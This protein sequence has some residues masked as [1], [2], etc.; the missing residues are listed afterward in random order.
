MLE[1]MSTTASLLG[2]GA[3]EWEALGVWAVG[4]PL[5]V[6]GAWQLR[7]AHKLRHEQTRPFVIAEMSSRSI[8]VILSVRNIGPTVA[9]NVR[10]SLPEGFEPSGDGDASWKDSVAFTSGIAT[11]APKQEIRF[12]LD[13]FL[14]RVKSDLPM[15]IPVDIDYDGPDG[16]RHYG[17][18]H[19]VLDLEAYGPAMQADNTMHDLVGEIK[20]V[21]EELHKW[22]DGHQGLRV[23]SHDADRKRA[24]D[25]R[26]LHYTKI[27]ELRKSEGWVSA[28]RYAVQEFRRRFGLHEW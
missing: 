5:A 13:S 22:T 28:G 20:K 6:Y 21:R 23:F 9:R 7:D 16:K 26:P 2:W 24:R 11:M 15:R 4:L 1:T 12:Y 17:P 8:L 3:A 27:V 19:F 14:R 25:H 10:V 18:E